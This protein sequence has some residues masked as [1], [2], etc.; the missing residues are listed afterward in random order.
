VGDLVQTLSV[1]LSIV[2]DSS[3][4]LIV[5][6]L[7]AFHWLDRAPREPGPA[8][9]V[10]ERRKALVGLTVLFGLAYLLKPWFL[11]AGMSGLT[12]FRENLKLIPDVL[13]S[14][15][16]GKLWFLGG[17]AIL[18]LIPVALL[19]S[20]KTARGRGVTLLTVVTILLLAWLKSASS[21]AGGQGDFTRLEAFQMLHILATAMWSGSILVSGFVVLPQL[22]KSHDHAAVWSYGGRLS[23]MA[24]YAVIAVMLTGIYTTDKEL[25]GTLSG[26]WTG[27]WGKILLTKILFVTAAL[28]LGGCSRV[29]CVGKQPTEGKLRLFLRLLSAEAGAM[30]VVLCLSGLLGSTSP[31]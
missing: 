30:V 29:L 19:A 24:T 21:H 11:A 23:A 26:L 6:V 27:A 5:G 16:Q 31:M 18:L 15:H 13:S 8:L 3:F 9:G 4:A 20:G 22:D 7:L 28:V 1:A 10:R 14:T 2:S 12:G 17:L 25:S